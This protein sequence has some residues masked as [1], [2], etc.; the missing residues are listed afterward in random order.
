MINK[1]THVPPE[2]ELFVKASTDYPL[3]EA[4]NFVEPLSSNQKRGLLIAR[5]LINNEGE[6]QVSVLNMT[7][8]S[9]KQKAGEVVGHVCSVVE[10]PCTPKDSG[11]C[12]TLP[13][14]LKPLVDHLSDELTAEQKQQFSQ[15]L[16]EFQ[17]IF[18]GPDGKL[19]QTDLAYHRIETGDAKPIKIPP[20]KCPIA[21]PE[22]IETELDKM[23][24]E[25]VIE[26][27]DSPWSAP[28]CLVK[29][30]DGTY[31][32]AIDFLKLGELLENMNQSIVGM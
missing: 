14:H 25:K 5:S 18:V 24:Q 23:L 17:D 4:L 6:S 19:G 32:F 2:S 1:T 22:I 21:Q 11:D 13:D 30:S 29:K 15:L 8:K 16:N 7:D 26:P 9:I 3:Y 28:I 12:G 10:N 31:R 27:S 20:R